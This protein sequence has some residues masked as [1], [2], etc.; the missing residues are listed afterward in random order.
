M[1][2]DSDVMNEWLFEYCNLQYNKGQ[3]HFADTD[4]PNNDQYGWHTI[5]AEIPMRFAAIFTEY[6]WEH[7]VEETE[8]PTVQEMKDMFYRWLEADE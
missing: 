3:F 7:E 1:K 5:A 2:K 6:Y 4:D 8:A